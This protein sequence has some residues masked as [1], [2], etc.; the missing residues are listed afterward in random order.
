MSEV[1]NTGTF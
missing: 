1:H